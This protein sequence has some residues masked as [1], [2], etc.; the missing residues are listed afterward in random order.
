[1]L[2]NLLAKCPIEQVLLVPVSIQVVWFFAWGV[3]R[4]PLIPEISFC[5]MVVSGRWTLLISLKKI[6]IPIF[7]VTL[8]VW[9]RG[10]SVGGYC[11]SVGNKL[12]VPE[13][14][15]LMGGYHWWMTPKPKNPEGQQSAPGTP[16]HLS[17]SSPSCQYNCCVLTTAFW[18]IPGF[19]D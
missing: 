2:W 19:R 6:F 18:A 17:S 11:Q 7:C 15:Q 14:I 3:P 16:P 8:S 9:T 5:L 12:M 10:P 13:L 1:M 4:V